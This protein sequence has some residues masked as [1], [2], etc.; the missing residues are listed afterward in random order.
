MQERVARLWR[1]FL[2]PF[3]QIPTKWLKASSRLVEAPSSAHSS[4]APGTEVETP[5]GEGTVS[6]FRASDRVYVID[7]PF[8]VAYVQPCDVLT[9]TREEYPISIPVSDDPSLAVP[10]PEDAPLPPEWSVFYGNENAYIFFRLLHLLYERLHN[11]KEA[12]D[13]VHMCCSQDRMKELSSV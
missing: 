8:G 4:L 6:M 9:E 11:A 7:L 5:Y 2:L 10:V 1:E 12:C 3:L 13:K